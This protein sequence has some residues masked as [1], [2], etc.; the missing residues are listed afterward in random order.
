[1]F[2][3]FINEETETRIIKQIVRGCTAAQQLAGIQAQAG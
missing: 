1:M 2:P 3:H